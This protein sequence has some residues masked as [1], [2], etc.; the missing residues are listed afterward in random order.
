MTGV[1][2]GDTKLAAL[3]WRRANRVERIAIKASNASYEGD[4]GSGGMVTRRRP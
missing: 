2:R 3:L 4:S 1:W